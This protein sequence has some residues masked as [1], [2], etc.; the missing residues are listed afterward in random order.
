VCFLSPR[1]VL[2]IENAQLVGYKSYQIT[3]HGRSYFYLM[4]VISPIPPYV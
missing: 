2:G 4:Y 3:N 1:Q